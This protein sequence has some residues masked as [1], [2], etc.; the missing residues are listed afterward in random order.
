MKQV[1]WLPQRC[2]SAAGWFPYNLHRI[3]VVECTTSTKTEWRAFY[4]YLYGRFLSE[5]D[6]LDVVI[7]TAKRR[8]DA[9]CERARRGSGATV[10]LTGL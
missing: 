10:T 6:S 2:A 9:E 8:I 3:Y 7:A 5:A 4:G 1:H